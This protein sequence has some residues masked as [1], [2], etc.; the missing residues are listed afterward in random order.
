MQCLYYTNIVFYCFLPTKQIN[1]YIGL[2]TWVSVIGGGV[3]DPGLGNNMV[4]P[5]KLFFDVSNCRLTKSGHEIFANSFPI[6]KITK[7]WINV[8]MVYTDSY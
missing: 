5:W 8:L 2:Y 1:V 7:H 3:S 6:G 4:T